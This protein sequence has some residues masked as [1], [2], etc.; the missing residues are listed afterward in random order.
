MALFG[1]YTVDRLLKCISTVQPVELKGV[2]LL[3]RSHPALF[4]P[5]GI[6]PTELAEA[7]VEL[8]D[9]TRAC[10]AAQQRLTA[11]RSI[12]LTT[13]DCGAFGL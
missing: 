8:I 1:N 3:R 4:L 10:E 11:L 13:V 2:A 5:A 12:P 9:Y 6:D 7:A